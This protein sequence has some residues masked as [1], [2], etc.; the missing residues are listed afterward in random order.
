MTM[1]MERFDWLA[2]NMA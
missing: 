1:S 2:R